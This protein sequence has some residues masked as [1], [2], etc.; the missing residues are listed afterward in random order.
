M[1]PPGDFENEASAVAVEIQLSKLLRWWN[2]YRKY[3]RESSFSN[4]SDRS[5][6]V[7][8]ERRNFQKFL[9]NT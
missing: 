9:W 6:I 2:N 7:L 4:I 8:D 3:F 1:E 5:F